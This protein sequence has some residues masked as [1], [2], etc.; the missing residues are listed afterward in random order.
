MKGHQNSTDRLGG[1]IFAALGVGATILVIVIASWL[2]SIRTT[3][4][5][6]FVT[7][8]VLE[9]LSTARFWIPAVLVASIIAGS[10]VGSDTAVRLLGYLWF[11]EKPRRPLVSILMWGCLLLISGAAHWVAITHAFQKT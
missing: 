11:T 6:D 10:V 3:K 2:L 4:G 8:A 1:V 5:A 9:A 7:L